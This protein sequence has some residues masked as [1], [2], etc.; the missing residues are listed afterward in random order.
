MYK[1]ILL[2]SDGSD[3][4]LRA[5]DH[6]FALAKNEEEAV[7]DIIYVVDTKHAKEDVIHHWGKTGPC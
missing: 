1:K 7:V 2:A 5:A 4:A 6:A 3:H